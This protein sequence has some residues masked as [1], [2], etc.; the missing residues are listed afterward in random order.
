MTMMT[1]SMMTKAMMTCS[2]AKACNSHTRHTPAGCANGCTGGEA[3][4]SH[5]AS[6][7]M[8]AKSALRAPAACGTH[9]VPPVDLQAA[10]RMTSCPRTLARTVRAALVALRAACA[11]PSAAAAVPCSPKLLAL[12]ARD[13]SSPPPA[14][15]HPRQ[16]LPPAL[17]TRARRTSRR[18]A[19][20]A[21]RV[22]SARRVRRATARRRARRCA[23]PHI[24]PPLLDTPPHRVCSRQALTYA[25]HACR[26][27]RRAGARLEAQENMTRPD[28]S[29]CERPA[30]LC[31]RAPRRTARHVAAIGP[32]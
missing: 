7:L 28:L 29:A 11:C 20:R 13:L 27:G 17:M 14:Q 32:D 8:H 10:E 30:L 15:T 16:A 25:S 2:T 4:A 9:F 1:T 24:R 31:E 18:S 26:A 22:S 23:P 3:S 21:R 19:R 5:R 12:A 6:G